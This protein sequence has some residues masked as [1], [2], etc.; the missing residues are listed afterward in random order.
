[1][2]DKKIIARIIAELSAAYPNW[3]ANEY[4]AEIYYQDLQDI[5]GDLL[6]VAAKHC[7]TSTSRDQRF[8]PSAGEIRAAA[9][10][11]KR[12]ERSI[13]SPIEAWGELLRVP[14]TEEIKRA[15]DETD[16]QG[17]TIVEVMPYQWSH[18]LVRKVA[19]MLGFPRFPDWDSESFER[20][21]FLKAY[22]S[23]LQSYIKQDAQPEAVKQYIETRRGGKALPMGEA[24]KQLKG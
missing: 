12:Q 9:A 5:D 13:P 17:R 21:V 24:V 1:M 7:R 6:M 3:Q 8:A 14:K 19:I 11:I 18:P 22:E 15:T 20:A 2:S 16:E 4:T 10:D 23:E